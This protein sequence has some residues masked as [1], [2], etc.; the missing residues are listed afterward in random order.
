MDPQRINLE[1]GI[2]VYDADAFLA[3]NQRPDEAWFAPE[4]WESRSLVTARQR[5]RGAALMIQTPAGP[6][7][8]RQYL[9]GGWAAKLTRSRYW[10]TGYGLSR[11]VREFDVLVKL[12]DMGLPAPRPMAALCRR[13]GLS[14]S[15]AII[16]H[17]IENVKPLD[18]LADSLGD[19]DWRA[20]GATIKTFHDHGLVHADLNVRNILVR[21]DGKVFLVDFDR[22]CFRGNAR[23][24]FERNLKRLRRSMVKIGLQENTGF[25][26]KAWTQLL[27]GY[28]S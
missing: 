10:F 13:H 23:Q 25:S 3:A 26:E 19:E 12:A 4:Y 16:M 24:S 7:V 9:R 27:K 6:G 11:P 5:G 18:Q 22:A 2:I 15:G 8:L 1:S 21:R 14:A 17:E 20:V 28:E